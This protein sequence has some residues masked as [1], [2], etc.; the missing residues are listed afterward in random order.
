M[1]KYK[2]FGWEN[3]DSKKNGELFPGIE[4]PRDLYDKLEKA[5][6]KET[7]APRLRKE[8]S[9]DN[10]T[11]GQCSITAFLAQDIFGGEGYGIALPSGGVHCYN[12]VGDRTF[13][14]AS[15][16]FGDVTLD[17]SK[18]FLQSREEHFSDRDKYDRYLLLKENVKKVCVG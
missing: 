6:T 2:F 4:T 14:L 5:W 1:K 12:V 17:Y 13:D 10:K 15:E 16:Q 3:A 7:C 9:E 18:G 8:W 11:A